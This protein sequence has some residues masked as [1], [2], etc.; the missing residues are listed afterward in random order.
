MKQYKFDFPTV[1]ETEGLA[2]DSIDFSTDITSALDDIASQFA[3]YTP[4]GNYSNDNGKAGEA[5]TSDQSK[6]GRLSTDPSA[7]DPSK[8]ESLSIEPSSSDSSKDE[9]LSTESFHWKRDSISEAERT[10]YT[11]FPIKYE[12]HMKER[13]AKIQREQASRGSSSTSDGLK[14]AKPLEAHE[15]SSSFSQRRTSSPTSSS[16]LPQRQTSSPT[17][18]HEAGPSS[19]SSSASDF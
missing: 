18:S 17:S 6:N 4:G 16:S 5:S 15:S 9:N 13:A 8:Y 11:A 12:R 7:P 19:N 2:Q 10:R 1:P 14:R 3:D